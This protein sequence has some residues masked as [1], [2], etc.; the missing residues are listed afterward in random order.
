R[1]GAVFELA[2]WQDFEG[3]FDDLVRLHQARW[4]AEGKPGCFAAPRFTE[5]HRCLIR[6][7]LP[8]GRAVLARLSQ[9]RQVYAVLY[10]FVTRT[11]FDFYQ[12]GVKRT[13]TGP[14]ESPGTTANLLLMSRLVER[15]VTQYDFLRGSSTY[16]Q[17]LATEDR[18]L[19]SPR[20]QRSTLRDAVFQASEHV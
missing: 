9:G 8:Q 12:S 10:G 20:C 6:A 2:G 15:G 18:Q 16:K 5:F 7:W 11:K 4:T 3:F 17:K 1:A 19:V 14:F 13:E